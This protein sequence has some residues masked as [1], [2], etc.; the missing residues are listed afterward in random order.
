MSFK[1]ERR[2]LTREKRSS[3]LSHYD[4]TIGQLIN[5]TAGSEIRQRVRTFSQSSSDDIIYALRALGGIRDSAVIIHGAIG[6][7]ESGIFWGKD[8]EIPWYSTNLDER[9]SIMGGDD[10][11]QKA[12]L[13]AYEETSP[14]AIFIVGTPVVAIN[15]DDVHSVILELEEELGIPLIAISTDGFK[16]K[17]PL[18]GLDIVSHA[19]LR[20]VIGP[21][22]EDPLKGDDSVNVISFLDSGEN[23]LAVL[24]ILRELGIKTRLLPQFASIE[25]IANAAKAKGSIV[26][27]SDEGEYLALELEEVYGVPYIRTEAPVG[28]RGTKRFIQ[29]IRKAFGIR[30]SLPQSLAHLESEAERYVNLKP[31]AG[32]SVFL[33]LPLPLAPPFVEFVEQ[34]GGDVGGLSVDTVDLSNRRMIEELDGLAH[35]LPVLVAN[36]QPFEKANI[37]SKNK[38]DYYFAV[39]DSG[40]FAL[41]GGALP[42]SLTGV[43]IYGFE[44]VRNIVTSIKRSEQAKLF[45]IHSGLTEETAYKPS[46]LRKS[47]NWYIK[48][49]VK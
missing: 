44:G 22:S 33:D 29:K 47:P 20:H 39:R 36:G 11:L 9:D 12:I 7:A 24:R 13:R 15:N 16:S 30:G 14:A 48:Q 19:L 4:G 41:A 8:R 38:M 21:A 35:S 18:S 27:N 3:A 42:I 23:V 32:A 49:E 2:A 37:L 31:L 10:K 43:G 40:A 25:E 26:L 5:D 17:T 6:C 28:I 45:G 1:D 34:L 46:W